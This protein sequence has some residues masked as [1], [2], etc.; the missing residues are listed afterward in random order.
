MITALRAVRQSFRVIRV[1]YA[2]VVAWGRHETLCLCLGDSHAAIFQQLQRERVLKKT[3]FVV[4][5]IGGATARG[6]SNPNSVTNALRIFRGLLRVV[7]RSVRVFLMLGEVDCGFLIWHN[8]ETR[9]SSVEG[10][11]ARTQGAFDAFVEELVQQG[12]RV[13]LVEVPLPTVEDYACWA[14]L[15]SQRRTI[16]APLTDRTALTSRF[17]MHVRALGATTGSAVLTYEERTI[18][19]TTGLLLEEFRNPDPLNHHLAAEPFCRLLV[20]Q[21]SQLG[22]A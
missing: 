5:W 15:E 8:A 17:N 3:R 2:L 22:Y 18:D 10:E 20:A 21:L 7:P 1:W 13:V 6:L 19:S 11:Y 9:G 16:K 14:G 4:V 12:R